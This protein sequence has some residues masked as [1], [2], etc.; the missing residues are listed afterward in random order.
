M[1]LYVVL[2][3]NNDKL[4]LVRDLKG[5]NLHFYKRRRQSYSRSPVLARSP[6]I[7]MSC[8]LHYSQMSEAVRAIA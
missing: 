8:V 3:V 4:H 5:E 6:S 1:P 7:N 2:S